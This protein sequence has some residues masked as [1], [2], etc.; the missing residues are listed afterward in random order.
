M[1]P[2]TKADASGQGE[3]AG[4]GG[5]GANAAAAAA[6]AEGAVLSRP[7][8]KHPAVVKLLQRETG[9]S[10]TELA[11]ATGWLPHTARAALTGL[12]KRALQIGKE[13]VHGVTDYRVSVGAATF[14]VE[15]TGGRYGDLDL[16]SIWSFRSADLQAH[17]GCS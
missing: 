8:S 5:A 11:D 14:K 7:G 6:L 13:K 16:L 2:V 4:G 17:L 12:R 15:A 3:P 9:A 10:V 1:L